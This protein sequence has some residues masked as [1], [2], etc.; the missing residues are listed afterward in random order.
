[1]IERTATVLFTNMRDST[2]LF[3]RA[4][5]EA[6][7]GVLRA[8][9]DVLRNAIEHQ[10]GRVVK[11]VGDGV[12]AVFDAPSPAL[13]AV[14]RAHELM[15]ADMDAIQP[16][17]MKAGM[18]HGTVLVVDTDQRDDVIGTT[19]NLAAQLARASDGGDVVISADAFR[20][21]AV[22]DITTRHELNV[23]TD[24]MLLKGSTMPLR[25][26]KLRVA[27]ATWSRC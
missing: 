10:G 25:Y 26:H 21:D 3:E 7:F 18:H 14:L 24:E 9:F 1:M 4:G 16:V 6:A 8:H 11:T 22:Q 23:A 20:D 19:V 12:M 13:R 2:A 5:N 15:A 27:R 17:H